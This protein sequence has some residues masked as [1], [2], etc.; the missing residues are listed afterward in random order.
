LF[1]ITVVGLLE[2]NDHLVEYNEVFRVVQESGDHPRFR[3]MARGDFRLKSTSPAA[4][5]IGL[6]P[7]SFEEIGLYTDGLRKGA[8]KLGE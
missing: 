6:R 7:I 8:S 5:Q 2:G 4:L 3:D 1:K